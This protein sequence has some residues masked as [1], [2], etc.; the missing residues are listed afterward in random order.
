M[1][2]FLIT[3]SGVTSLRV[4]IGVW[5]IR[6]VR[7][8]L[9]MTVWFPVVSVS[10]KTQVMLTIRS[11]T[12]VLFQEHCRPGTQP[13]PIGISAILVSGFWLQAARA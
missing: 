13:V 10:E 3:R 7:T 4:G 1:V 8:L 11:P 12:L 9:M 2:H 6:R 5:S